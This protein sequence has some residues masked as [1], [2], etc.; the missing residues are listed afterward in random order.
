M[1]PCAWVWDH[2]QLIKADSLTKTDSASPGSHLLPIG[3]QEGLGHHNPPPRRW[4]LHGLVLCRSFTCSI[5]SVF[6]CVQPFTV[7][8]MLF[9][10]SCSLPLA[11]VFNLPSLAWWSLSPVRGSTVRTSIGRW[12]PHCFWFSACPPLV[13][14]CIS[15]Q[16]KEG[17]L[18]RFENV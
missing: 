11:V 1:T 8:R 13:S 4:V 17:F 2:G 14:V 16:L 6:S 15:F 10:N 12:A 9:C 18:V 5:A 7:W 3:P